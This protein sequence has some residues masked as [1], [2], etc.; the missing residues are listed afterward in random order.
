[1]KKL[2]LMALLFCGIYASGF[3][4]MDQMVC[5]RNNCVQVEV[6][7]NNSQREIGLMFRPNLEANRGMLFIFDAPDR[8]GFWMK[9]VK[10]PLDIIWIAEDKTIVDLKIDLPAC[11]TEPCPTYVPAAP[12]KYAVE[13]NAG[14][15]VKWGLRIGDKVNF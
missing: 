11:P 15:V 3:C 2:M 9:N 7:Q 12:A 1:M 14:S 6:A 10:F 4:A 13:V 5:F 8:Y